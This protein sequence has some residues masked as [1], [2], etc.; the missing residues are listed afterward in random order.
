MNN[1]LN[2]V[3]R[4]NLLTGVTC[5]LIGSVYGN[6]KG[7]VNYNNYAQTK[8][9]ILSDKELDKIFDFKVVAH[10][11]FYGSTFGILGSYPLIS[12]PL[13]LFSFIYDKVIY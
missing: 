5:G 11:L 7:I 9:E 8:K 6:Y 13:I 12:M 3:F 10:T 4:K 2:L 1:I